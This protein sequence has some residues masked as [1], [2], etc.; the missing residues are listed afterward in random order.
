MWL[1]L[2][3][4]VGEGGDELLRSLEAISRFVDELRVRLSGTGLDGL[5]GAVAAQA[6]IR[7][8]LDTVSSN[9]LDE[10]RAKIAT[11]TAALAEIAERLA[12]LRRL[13]E[14]LPR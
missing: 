9:E 14:A 3:N 13:K 11:L 10:M 2:A 5:E 1:A 12:H 6:R 8:A 4:T 7:A